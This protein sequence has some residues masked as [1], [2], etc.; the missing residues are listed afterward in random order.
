[1]RGLATYLPQ[2]A[3]ELAT[4]FPRT[5]HGLAIVAVGP[6]GFPKDRY[7]RRTWTLWGRQLRW[8]DCQEAL[9]SIA[10]VTED[11]I[12]R[13]QAE[14]DSEDLYSSMMA[15][16][17]KTW[18]TAFLPTRPCP[19]AGIVRAKGKLR[20]ATRRVCEGLGIQIS[21][22]EWNIAARAALLHKERA[23][24]PL[25]NRR[26]WRALLD[27]GK[28][29]AALG[30]AV[31]FY[32]ATWDGS[33]A[34]ER[35]LGQDDAIIGEH[36]GSRGSDGDLY[37]ALL[38]L[39]IEGPQS[40]E[41]MFTRGEAGIMYLTDFSR[42]AAQQW[43]RLYGRRFT[44]AASVRKDKGK[45][46]AP[47]D[48]RR[49]DKGVQLRARAAYKDLCRVAA[50]DEAASASTPGT[51]TRRD[52]V[53]GV[54]RR[55]LM[56]AVSRVGSADPRAK[57]VRYRAATAKKLAEKRAQRLWTGTPHGPPAAR[58]G[59]SL[60]VAG[61]SRDAVVGGVRAAQFWVRR[62]GAPS[63]RSVSAPAAA[64]ASAQP[65]PPAPRGAPTPAQGQGQVVIH[66][67]LDELYRKRVKDPLTP[68][69]LIWLRA[70]A[71]G[72]SVTTTSRETF[73]FTSVVKTRR[74]ILLGAEFTRKHSQLHTALKEIAASQ[75]SQWRLDKTG[76]ASSSSSAVPPSTHRIECKRDLVQFLLH[77]RRM[78]QR[79]T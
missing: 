50:Q 5:C 26:A 10:V 61:G 77:A 62:K 33:G 39:K 66:D 42:K 22:G 37:S 31:R 54:D 52:T 68:E 38:E 79:R 30:E 3:T 14:F 18:S 15:F 71:H 46:A 67:T 70:V 78:H 51:E 20:T 72:G 16:D 69:L 65:P 6:S 47:P 28:L 34:V 45:T 2:L 13:L 8:Q 57:T 76:G 36:V 19:D 53:L 12:G 7:G 24:P 59:G 17:L 11:V 35:G 58:L 21:P 32:L 27:E 49:T 48:T 43:L 41:T 1:M 44:C 75:G 73:V 9:A 55:K 60:A 29:P 74:V 23:N 4:D 64:A 63:P 25:D 56:T 40:E